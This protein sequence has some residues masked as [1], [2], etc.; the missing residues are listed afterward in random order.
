MAKYLIIAASSTI[1]QEVV[2][3]LLSYGHECITSARDNSKITPDIL[4]DACDFD[5]VEKAFVD[6]GPFDGAVNCAGSLFLKPAH[7][8]NYNGFIETIN[9]SL[10]TSFALV[11]AAGKHMRNGGSI[12][13]ISS[14]AA[15]EGLANHEA[16]AAAKAGVIGLMRSAAATYA[17]QNLRFNA[18]APG[19]V[20]TNL[21]QNLTNNE[22]SRNFSTNMHALGRLGKPL[23]IARAICFLLDKE[24]DWITG[25]VWAIDGGLSCVRPKSKN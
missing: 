7:L 23:D 9:S 18:I 15:I 25:Q 24:N 13:L 20:E 21:T 14:A 10:V 11:R 16:I 19:L 3:T 8:T 1:G 4:L 22:A 2:K 6:F 17:G 5:A 12:V